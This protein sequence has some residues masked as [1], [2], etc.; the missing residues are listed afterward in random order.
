MAIVKFM[1]QQTSLIAETDF[2]N[3]EARILN[4]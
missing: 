1:A 4:P 3:I 2:L